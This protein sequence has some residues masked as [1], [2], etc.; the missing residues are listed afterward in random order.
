VLADH[1]AALPR[2][3]QALPGSAEFPSPKASASGATVAGWDVDDL[4][5]TVD[6]LT[7]NGVS[8]EQY[9]QGELKTN[10]KG[11]AD[12]G[13]AKAAWCKDPD[14]NVLGILEYAS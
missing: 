13:D 5:A 2:G 9:D 3:D 10:E 11:I 8:F 14:G 6:E 1:R 12:L 7:S 4:D